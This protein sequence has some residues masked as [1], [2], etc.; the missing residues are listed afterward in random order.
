MAESK[1]VILE[2]GE[3]ADE[4]ERLAKLIGE[5]GKGVVT[6]GSRALL[7]AFF[8]MNGMDV[9]SAE[10]RAAICDLAVSGE[11]AVKAKLIDNVRMLPCKAETLL[12]FISGKG[13]ALDTL[14]ALERYCG[15]MAEYDAAADGFKAFVLMLLVCGITADRLSVDLAFSGGDEFPDRV[16]RFGDVSGGFKNAEKNI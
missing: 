11:E 12:D 5:R 14:F 16:F 3:S 6:V 15:I 13:S 2:A 1:V 9:K 7:E 10:I 4:A 8:A